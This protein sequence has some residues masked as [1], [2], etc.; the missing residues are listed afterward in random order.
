MATRNTRFA[1]GALAGTLALTLTACG[2]SDSDNTPTQAPTNASGELSGELTVWAWDQTITDVAEAFTAEHPDVT[3]DVV[4]VGTG[5]DQYVALQNAVA[6]ESGGPDL[7]QIEYYAVPQ[8]S[9]GQALADIGPMGADELDGTFTTGPWSAVAQGDNVWGLPLDSGPMAMF[10][11]KEVFDANNVD[12]P[13][14]WDEFLD[15]A[16]TL[17]EQGIYIVNDTGDAGFTTSMIWQAGGRPYQV[18]DTTVSVD[19]TDEGT[20]KF[21]E[22]WQTMIDEELVAPISSWSDEWYQALGDGSV[23]SLVIGAWMPGNLETGVPAGAGKWAVADMPQWSDSEFTTSENGGSSM[24]VMKG[25]DNQALAYE[26][27]EFT[28]AGE[29]IDI[30]VD[31]GAF[32]ATVDTLNEPGFLDREF[33]YFGGQKVNEVLAKSAEGVAEGWQYLPFQVYANS[34]FN[35]FSANAYNGS[36]PLADALTQWGDASATYGGQQGFTIE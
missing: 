1:V 31:G 19:F 2:G 27:L 7:A 34:V 30:R 26:F 15:A 32:P 11:N 23:A 10:Y 3:V 12:V 33:E 28:A 35:D 9:I 29:G 5:N 22:L 8:F 36:T 20:A 16:R 4:N 18:N 21:A 6:A 24:A 17:K 25:S 14:T 13:T